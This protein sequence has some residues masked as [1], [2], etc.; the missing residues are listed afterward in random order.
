M[1]G[2]ALFVLITTILLGG[3]V[4]ILALVW[5]ER[6]A[7][8]TNIAAG[9]YTIF[10]DDEPIGTERD[11]MWRPTSGTEPSAAAIDTAKRGSADR[12]Q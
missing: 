4:A 1:T 6:H 3:A 11:M 10:D 2:P 12:R 7:Q 5:A 8:F 9:A